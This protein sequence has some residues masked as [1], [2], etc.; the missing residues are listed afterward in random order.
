[1]F[2][3]HY[4]FPDDPITM[5]T[6]NQTHLFAASSQ[7]SYKCAASQNVEMDNVTLEVSEFRYRAFGTT[8][9]DTYPDSGKHKFVPSHQKRDLSA[10][11]VEILQTSMR[12][13]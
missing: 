11:R 4:I 2:I 3:L 10:V 9:K 6:N 1:M 5:T 7:G 8:T 13:H 12:S